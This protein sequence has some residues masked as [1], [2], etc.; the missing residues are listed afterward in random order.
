MSASID[1]VAQ[2][3]C[4]R[5]VGYTTDPLHKEYGNIHVDEYGDKIYSY[6]RH[7]ELARPLRNKKREAVAFLLNGDNFSVSTSRHQASVRSVVSRTGLP[8]VVIPY[9]AL[10]AAGID[11]NSVV[12]LEDLPPGAQRIPHEEP[13]T[14]DLAPAMYDPIGHYREG[15]RFDEEVGVWRW[16]TYRHWL[17]ESLI[18]AKVTWSGHT[19][20]KDCRGSK[21]AEGPVQAE[22]HKSRYRYT[23]DSLWARRFSPRPNCPTCHGNGVRFWTR[24]RT[25]KFLSGF[26]HNEARR[27]YFFTELPKTDATTVAAAYEALKPDAVRLAEQMGREVK[28]QGDIFAIELAG[29]TFRDLRKLNARVVK[30]G[31]LW[32]TNHEATEVA[33]LPDGTTLI[34]GVLRHNPSGRR[35]DHARVK[36][37]KQWMLAAKNTV[38]IAA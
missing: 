17:G 18:Q 30:H 25:A 2:R 27:S 32:G 38:P 5:I 15:L 24:T 26:D 11:L 19:R 21:Y 9:T 1:M 37:G 3:W 23:R 20:C 12:I 31:T 28:R 16:H 7:F 10:G 13:G 14:A 22:W 33:Y 36:I 29:F 8:S 4:D 34:R 35:P 6:G